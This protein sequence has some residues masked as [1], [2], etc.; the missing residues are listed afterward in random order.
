MSSQ[1]SKIEKVMKAMSPPMSSVEN[2]KLTYNYK[3]KNRSIQIK[4]TQ[5]GRKIEKL[6]ENNQ[7]IL[8][9]VV[10]EN[11]DF[12]PYELVKD[13]FPKISRSQYETILITILNLKSDKN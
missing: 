2:G 9:F 3:Y 6:I 11:F 4:D 10:R 8:D 12:L 13:E 1:I 5:R 7:K